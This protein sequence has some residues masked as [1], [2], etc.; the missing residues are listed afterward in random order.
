MG[1]ALTATATAPGG[2]R[3]HLRPPRFPP[4]RDLQRLHIALPCPTFTPCGLPMP[5]QVKG[6]SPA[7]GE[8]WSCQQ[9]WG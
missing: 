8:C 6:P 7:L 4:S 2:T 5:Q 3:V 1:L 9:G